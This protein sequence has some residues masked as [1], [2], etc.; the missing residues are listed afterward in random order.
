MEDI[1]YLCQFEHEPRF[2]SA[3]SLL[4]SEFVSDDPDCKVPAPGDEE[5]H[6]DDG[7]GGERLLRRFLLL[8]DL[9][10]WDEMVKVR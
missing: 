6:V 3:P 9:L 8:I 7:C 10:Q 1:I 2:E 5:E 4:G